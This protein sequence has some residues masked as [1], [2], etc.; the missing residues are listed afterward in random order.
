MVQKIEA[1]HKPHL[2]VCE[3]MDEKWFLI[4]FLN[5]AALSGAPFFSRDIQVVDFGGN[6][7]LTQELEVLRV[8]P[9]FSEVRSLLIVRDA[10][11]DGEAAVR[12]IRHSLQRTGLP[13]P[14]GPGQWAPG[15][16]GWASSYSPTVTAQWCGERWRTSASL[17]WSRRTGR[18][19]WERSTP[20]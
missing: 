6:E 4:R 16:R 17:F 12:E 15:G 19:C 14:D 20:S 8:S 13:V 18:R 11:R 1:L 10:E 7:E 3:G 2:I 9:G 5:S